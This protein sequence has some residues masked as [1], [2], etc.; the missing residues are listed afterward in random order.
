MAQIVSDS[1]SMVGSAILCRHPL[2]GKA[3]VRSGRVR[4]PVFMRERWKSTSSPM[5]LRRVEAYALSG[6]GCREYVWVEMD[7]ASCSEETAMLRIVSAT[8]RVPSSQERWESFGLT[9]SG[10]CGVVLVTYTHRYPGSWSVRL[11]SRCCRVQGPASVVGPTN[12]DSA[13]R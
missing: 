1:K 4:W 2:S 13:L 9:R 7:C 10:D 5:R 11:A 6:V 3:E 8:S 12:S